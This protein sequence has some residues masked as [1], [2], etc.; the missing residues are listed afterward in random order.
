MN[1]RFKV[2]D[3][4]CQHCRMK[5]ENALKKAPAVR[6]VKID[7]DAKTVEVEHEGNEDDLRQAIVGAGYTPS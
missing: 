5:I 1:T 2:E 3:M 7:L 4:A 6:E